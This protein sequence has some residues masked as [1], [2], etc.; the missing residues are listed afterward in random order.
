MKQTVA[1]D[2]DD[3][4]AK[5]ADYIAR[6]LAAHSV[7]KVV[8]PAQW[9]SY[10]LCETYT[11]LDTASVCTILRK[12]VPYS[13][14]ELTSNLWPYV[15]ASIRKHGFT[16]MFVTSRAQIWGGDR[17]SAHADTYAWLKKVGIAV[18][19]SE[20]TVLDLKTTKATHLQMLGHKVVASI[21]D[22]LR[23]VD[24]YRK[25]FP[26]G[27]HCLS[28]GPFNRKV[29]DAQTGNILPPTYL[30]YSQGVG[31]FNQDLHRY[32]TRISFRSDR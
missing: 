32:L 27:F 6:A 4:V 14:L 16:P 22:N 23:E 29:R 11:D 2:L 19:P 8:D 3:T 7:C 17:D 1:I 26:G 24:E 10:N 25:V 30:V 18:E 31:L 13:S 20:L 12:E 5:T 9:P 21:D 15:V 28:A